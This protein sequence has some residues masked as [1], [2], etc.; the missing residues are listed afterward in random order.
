MRTCGLQ[1]YSLSR[2][3]RDKVNA[4]AKPP[5]YTPANQCPETCVALNVFIVRNCINQLKSIK[6]E[7]FQSLCRAIN[8]FRSRNKTPICS[9]TSSFL[10]SEDPGEKQPA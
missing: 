3:W 5:K 9:I 2:P 7:P 8:E 1:E 4:G 6:T 10:Q